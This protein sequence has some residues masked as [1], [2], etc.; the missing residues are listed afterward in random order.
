MIE[1]IAFKTQARTVDH[2]GRERTYHKMAEAELL[3]TESSST[4]LLTG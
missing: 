3:Y 4:R 1:T 2:L